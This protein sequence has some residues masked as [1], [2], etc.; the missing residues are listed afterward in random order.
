MLNVP[1]VPID[2][3]EASWVELDDWHHQDTAAPWWRWYWNDRQGWSATYQGRSHSLLPHNVVLIAPE[4]KFLARSHNRA[5]HLYLHFTVGPPFHQLT[6]QIHVLQLDAS[7]KGLLRS[8]RRAIDEQH[9]SR[10]A[11]CASALCAT[12]LLRVE[13]PSVGEAPELLAITQFMREHATLGTTNEELAGRL[14]MHPSSFARWFKRQLGT[15]PHAWLTARKI[16]RACSLLR[17]TGLSV[18]HIAEQL[19]FCDRFYFSRVFQRHRGC[20][21]SSFRRR[22]I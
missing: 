21:P 20:S 15:T 6:R 5:G 9:S 19:G 3:L 10:V 22:G 13:L 2:I 7:T 12:A 8:C 11:L 14:D 16:E 1:Q 4:T 17:F 18:E